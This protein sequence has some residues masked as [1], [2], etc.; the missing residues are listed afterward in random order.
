[1]NSQTA[2]ILVLIGQPLQKLYKHSAEAGE[3]RVGSL[4][5][6]L[7]VDCDGLSFGLAIPDGFGEVFSKCLEWFF[8]KCLKRYDVFLIPQLLYFTLLGVLGLVAKEGIHLVLEI[9]QEVDAGFKEQAFGL[10]DIRVQ[11]RVHQV[12]YDIN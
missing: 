6:G 5:F 11:V 10:F 2:L 4:C 1:M 3:G 9:R 12:K 8:L 7:G